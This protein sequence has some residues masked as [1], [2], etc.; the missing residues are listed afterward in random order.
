MHLVLFNP[1]AQKAHRRLP[2]SLLM[3]ARVLPDDV[4]WELCDA[5]VDPDAKARAEAAVARDPAGTLLLV[6]VMPGPQ[7]RQAVP[8]TRHVKALWPQLTVVWGGYF[9][10]VYT[11][12]CAREP[13]IDLVVVGQ[14][15]D[16][17]VDLIAAL[18]AGTDPALVS[19][20]AAWRDGA[21]VQGPPRRLKISSRYGDPPYD[22]VD[23]ERYAARTFLGRRTFNHHSSVGCPYTCN[24]C[25]VTT[26]ANG[27]WLAD[28]AA[29][30]V[31]VVRTLATR[32]G[33]DAIE[34]HDNNFFAAEKRVAAVAD[35]I[36]DLGLRWWGEGR[37]DTMLAWSD[38]TWRAMAESG[39]AMVFF[40]AESADQATLDAM[41]KGG[42]QVHETVELNL[43]A[44]AHGIRPEFSFVLGNPVDPDGDVDA[45][46]RLVRRLKA[47]NEACEIILYMYTP[48][49]L[50]GMY[51]QAVA[52]GF[53]F[54]ERLDDWLAPPWTLYEARR[55]AVTPWQERALVRRVY[56][57]EAVLHARYPS[58]SDQR[59][60]GWQRHALRWLSAPRWRAGR[61]ARPYELKALQ[62][63]WQYRRP[64]EMGF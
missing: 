45:T 58:V 20:V 47:D 40:G 44:R 62:K 33:A 13:A 61:Y 43:R 49:P 46:L 63:L 50:P 3:L 51:D 9:P 30:V 52:Q 42:L 37:I 38:A 21:L 19:G 5:N 54:P 22:A 25:A 32:Y 18:R 11:A 55:N 8:W 17:V 35:G 6:T 41:D 39:L 60:S 29:D 28:P 14:G 23:M 16:T 27:R 57:F 26:L 2:L 31:R 1:R 10:T 48:V 4:S 59:L 36:T 24:F 15:E 56:D 12:A 64:E 53:S 7:L 34:F